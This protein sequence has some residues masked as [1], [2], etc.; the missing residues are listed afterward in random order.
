MTE[1]DIAGDA[2]VDELT[3]RF[4]CWRI[5]RSQPR[6]LW[7]ATRRGNIQRGDLPRR[8]G[9]GITIGGVPTLAE[10]GAQ[11]IVQRELDDPEPLPVRDGELRLPL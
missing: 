5:W 4:P 8:A 2:G 11:L 10:L 1:P 3:A 9:W 6:G 7:W